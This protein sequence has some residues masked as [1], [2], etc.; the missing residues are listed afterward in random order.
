M[1]AHG[2]GDRSLR[3]LI[4]LLVV[5]GALLTVSTLAR[6]DRLDDLRE[7]LEGDVS[8]LQGELFTLIVYAPR[9]AR[10]VLT[11][12]L[13]LARFRTETDLSDTELGRLIAATPN[14]ARRL[15]EPSGYFNA[16]IDVQRTPPR[17][18]ER[19]TVTVTVDPG[20]PT[21]VEELKLLL[22]GAMLDA[23]N[24]GDE[25]TERRWKRLQ[26]R[27]DLDEG[28][29]FTQQAWSQSRTD[30]INDLHGYA[31][32]TA[33]IAGSSARIDADRDRAKLFVAVDSGPLF[34]IGE[35]RVEGLERTPASA[36][37]NVQPFASGEVYDEQMLVDYQEMLTRVGL[38][39]GIG[40]ELDNDPEQ[41]ANAT[42][43]LRLRERQFQ[44][45]SPSIGFSTDTGARVGLEYSHRR[46]F[47]RDWVFASRL[48]VGQSERIA[49]FDLLSYPRANAHRMVF[50][51]RADYLDAAGSITET[52]RARAGRLQEQLR[53]TRFGYAEFTRSSVKTANERRV[54]RATGL[55]FEW[56]RRELNNRLFPTRGSII[57]LNGGGGRANDNDG[58]KGQFARG[59]ARLTW[60]QPLGA[61]WFMQVR[62]EAAQV[63]ADD[64]LGIPDALL[65]R[66]GGDDSVRGYG[67]QTLGPKRDGATVGGR[68][69]VTGTFEVMKR[70]S[71]QL[72][73]WFG[74]V[75]VDAGDAADQWEDIDAA[76][77]IG[78]GVRW[79]SPVGPL[80]VD[81]AW[82]ERE[83]SLRLH[84]GVGV[85]F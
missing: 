27:W 67:Y 17:A 73:D 22:Q 29:F 56:T 42:V 82:G 40:V 9:E 81:I 51:L 13:D 14:Q 62:G 52:Q 11:Q 64:A 75:F 78:V 5:M 48:S 69:M 7:L 66:A 41:A 44:E 84:L 76:V 25:R 10:A 3:A 60:Y 80:R 70:I 30:L 28:S 32:P 24:E 18:G 72:P 35:V 26:R 2:L 20:P 39:D 15:L 19:P 57:T 49:N 43:I 4:R 85:S 54:D 16:V 12:H 34:R 8:T 65:F 33:S 68:K 36:A 79:R 47:D 46:P 55:Y 6:A 83:R 21:Q 53:F 31:Y 59:L 50:N 37:I 58:D 1:S 38:Y 77:G 61:G 23:I 74:A 71:P 63:F 45:A